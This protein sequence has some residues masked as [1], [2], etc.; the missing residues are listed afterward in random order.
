MEYMESKMQ[1]LYDAQFAWEE[2]VADA[3]ENGF[4]NEDMEP[5]KCYKCGHEEFTDTTKAADSGLV[6]E[7]Q[8][9]CAR[10]GQQNGY[11]AYGYWQV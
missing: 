5:I 6:T 8:R 11:W 9:D 4:I 3:I 10:C 1:E 2:E 7:K